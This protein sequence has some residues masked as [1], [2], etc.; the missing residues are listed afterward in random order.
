[1]RHAKETEAHQN[2][3]TRRGFIAIAGSTALAT[4]L[5]GCAVSTSDEAP[6]N[7]PNQTDDAQEQSTTLT[8]SES[9]EKEAVKD[10]GDTKMERIL[11]AYL[12]NTGNTQAVAEKIATITG[13]TLFRIEPK[14]PYSAA[15]LDYNDDNARC[16]RELND[17]TSR[18]AVAGTVSDWDSYDTVFLGYP[19]W[20]SRTPP[21]MQTFAESYNWAGK[22]VIPFCTS[23]SSSIG[24]SA[25]VLE[26]EASGST[27]VEGRRFSASTSKS[28][29]QDWIANL[30]I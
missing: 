8:D 22:T 20:W 19:I 27:W 6:D 11:V 17:P 5:G 30:G 9:S 10:A 15:D 14:E 18:P 7:P 2:L 29:L 24:Q 3:V 28:E 12:S 4:I 13:G 16:M 25:S 23:G 26:S 21:I 1:M